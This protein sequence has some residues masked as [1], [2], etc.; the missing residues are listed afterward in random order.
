[1]GRLKCKPSFEIS[2]KK[3]VKN[4][5]CYIR[6]LCL[7]HLDMRTI[8][9]GQYYTGS[10]AVFDFNCSDPIIYDGAIRRLLRFTRANKLKR[11]LLWRNRYY[12]HLNTFAMHIFYTRLRSL[13]KY[14][15]SILYTGISEQSPTPV[16]RI[17]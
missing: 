10:E 1:M 9:A 17:R 14:L 8:F 4:T 3:C 7:K 6:I 12:I 13:F 16:G 2:L 15:W 11:F 5:L